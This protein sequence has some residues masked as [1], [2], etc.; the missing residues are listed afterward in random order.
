MKDRKPL[1]NKWMAPLN[2]TDRLL[3]SF[4][5]FLVCV[6]L[7]F[8]VRIP[9]WPLLIL[10]DVAAA[11]I[12]CILASASRSTGS[13]WLRW[14]H[15][16]GAFP[17]VLFTF[18]QLHYMIGPIHG[19]RDFDRLLITADRWLFGTDPT[20]W[21]ARFAHPFLTELLQIA[22]ALFYIYF[23][24]VGLELYRKSDGHLFSYFRFTVV[25]GFLVSY[26]GYFFLPA[27]GPRFTL[28]NFS[29]M[30]SELPGLLFTPFLRR[31]VNFFESIPANVPSEI[32]H[33]A[34]QRDVFPSGHTMITLMVI[35]L[36]YHY[37]LKVRHSI[38]MAGLLLIFATVYLRYHY[39]IDDIAG[40]ILALLCIFTAKRLYA[41][42]GNESDKDLE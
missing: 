18:K 12:T 16:W 20:V 31:F 24:I 19:Q 3:I 5:G 13:R 6:N 39:L 4:W 11:A 9:Y 29:N 30:D 7:A 40:A 42:F 25:Y 1:F 22:Y 32:A 36:A 17:L 38:L 26:I 41:D 28:H 33:A 8:C 10:S 34:A 37:R 23:I 21:L 35:F 14:I 15:D 27:A 2:S